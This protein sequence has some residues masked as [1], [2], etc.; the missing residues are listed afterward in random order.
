MFNPNDVL[1]ADPRYFQVENGLNNERRTVNSQ[2]K[3]KGFDVSFS[4]QRTHG[5]QAMVTFSKTQVQA[6]RD[7]SEFKA[8]L[9][10]A[11]FLKAIQL[12][13]QLAKKSIKIGLPVAFANVCAAT[14]L[15]CHGMPASSSTVGMA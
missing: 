1:P 11:S 2:E 3:S 13:H 4:A 14:K 5:L 12:A 15:L 7:F 10:A 8:L 6:T 9:D